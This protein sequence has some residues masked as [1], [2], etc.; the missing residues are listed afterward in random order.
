MKKIDML[1]DARD[2]KKMDD[3][4]ADMRAKKEIERKV[5]RLTFLWSE[6]EERKKDAIDCIEQCLFSFAKSHLE[7]ITNLK[8]EIDEINST[9]IY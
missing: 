3:W 6:I 4:L 2:D 7:K 9:K 5:E 8:N 1:S